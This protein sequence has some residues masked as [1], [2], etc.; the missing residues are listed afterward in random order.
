MHTK[1]V[2]SIL[3]IVFGFLL[4]ISLAQAGE[5]DVTQCYSGTYTLL[6]P[7]EKL[8]ILTFDLN[9]IMRSN[10]SDKTFDNHTFHCIGMQRIY[11]KDQ[12]WE[13]GNCTVQAPD[14]SIQVGEFNVKNQDKTW[15]VLYGTGRYEGIESG[16]PYKTITE[17]K[18]IAPGTFQACDRSTGTFSLK[19]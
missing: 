14:G 2:I 10:T 11:G 9:G 4:T 19:K 6:S 7:S 18:P 5:Y 8:A 17:G 15:K 1:K 12:K 13:T 16:G 3:V